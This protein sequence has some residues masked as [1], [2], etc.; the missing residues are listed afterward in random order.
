MQPGYGTYNKERP[1]EDVI[2]SI[3]PLIEDS[4]PRKTEA[5]L[6]PRQYAAAHAPET[7]PAPVEEPAAQAAE[8]PATPG[9]VWPVIGASAEPAPAA[10]AAPA[11]EPPLP[12]VPPAPPAI[13][14]A[15]ARSRK[16]LI[17]GALVLIVLIVIGAVF[18]LPLLSGGE[19]TP[20]PEVITPT[21]TVP[22]TATVTATKTVVP[23][24]TAATNETAGAT[25]LPAAT[26]A[27]SQSIVP[28]S[29]VWVRVVYAD[30]FKGTVGTA[31][32]QMAVADTGEK[33]YQIATSEG[34][35]S[36]NLQKMDG[37]G[38][39]LLV[40]IYKDGTL[41]GE[42]STVVPKGVV[43]MLVN[44]KPSPTPTPT[45]TPTK[46]PIPVKTTAAANATVNATETA[47]T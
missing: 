33:L 16:P 18:I 27:A 26:T 41:V 37:S 7:P 20:T 43:D 23:V 1:I 38:D 44:L 11:V 10:E 36:V 17:I 14:S 25:V 22:V 24:T 12:P 19:K 30:L 8:T 32:D 4:V 13:P 42:K 9:V 40:E 28:T 2:H 3:E 29:G 46:I 45:P 47:S 21:T 31:G 35:V 34:I 15:P 39:K 5:P 6:M